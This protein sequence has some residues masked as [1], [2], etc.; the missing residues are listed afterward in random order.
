MRRHWRADAAAAAAEVLLTVEN[1]SGE[2]T[3]KL[4]DGQARSVP[5]APGAYA[6]VRS[7]TAIFEEGEPAG[8]NGLK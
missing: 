5:V 6:V 1:V 3:L 2:A 8:D 4:P 7:E